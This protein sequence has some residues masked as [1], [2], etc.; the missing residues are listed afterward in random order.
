MHA[1]Y[2]EATLHLKQCILIIGSV[3]FPPN[4]HTT[5]QDLFK[6]IKE[7]YAKHNKNNRFYVLLGDFNAY[8]DK[9]I[10]YKGPSNNNN[11]KY[12]Q[13]I[14]WLEQQLFTDTYRSMNPKGKKY[15]W[16]RDNSFTRIDYIWTDQKLDHTLLNAKIYEAAL[17]TNSDHNITSTTFNLSLITSDYK[18]STHRNIRKEIRTIFLYDQA[19][20]K[21]WE[22]Y[23]ANFQ[24]LLE[25]NGAFDIADNTNANVYDLNQLWDLISEAITLAANTNIPN[26]KVKI[27]S[28]EKT[29]KNK[30]IENS[31]E[32]R[33]SLLKLRKIIKDTKKIPTKDLDISAST[34]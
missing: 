34:N 25:K 8:R 27:G 23:A 17:I 28:L 33:R 32:E 21:E 2:I 11:K 1:Y 24:L 4:D 13:T 12:H 20:N 3:Y 9:N 31:S 7:E 10:D 30:D 22:E 29:T 5:A 16:S 14:S 26:K 19:S 18:R 15:T 6:Y